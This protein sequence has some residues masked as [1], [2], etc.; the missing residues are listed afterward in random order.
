MPV[1][2]DL[3]NTLVDRD[4]AFARWAHEAVRHWGGDES[5]VAWLVEA[6]AHGY[7]PRSDIA[8]LIFDR[9]E[10]SASDRESLVAVLR[11]EHVDYIECYPG[12]LSQL[13]GLA[14]IGERLVIVSNGDGRQ[15]RMKLERTGLAEIIDG[16]AIS[17]ELGIKKPDPRIFAAARNL[18][19]HDGLAWMV[20]DHVVADIAGARAV[21]FA[22]AWVSHERPWTEPWMPTLT[23]NNTA[24]LLASVTRAIQDDAVGLTDGP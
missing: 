23:E 20:G 7:T 10:P 18:A 15:Q 6:D 22:T 3:D 5:D 11:Y 1:F 9:L 13:E 12:V 8:Q 21:G 24:A 14:A 16:S 2:L 17:G 19:G 4:G